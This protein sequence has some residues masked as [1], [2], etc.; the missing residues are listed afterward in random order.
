LAHLLRSSSFALVLAL[1]PLT[2]ACSVA[3]DDTLADNPPGGAVGGASGNAGTG[4]A[5]GSAAVGG[6]AG[7]GAGKAGQ[8][9]QAG[10]AEQGG[11]GGIGE[12]GGTGTIGGFGGT[13]E[14]G[15]GQAGAA[16]DSAG[17]AG[18]AGS[19]G[20]A[21]ES[22]AAGAPDVPC[23]ETIEGLQHC[24]NDTI[25]TCTDGAWVPSAAACDLG[26]ATKGVIA[27]CLS[28]SP[29]EASCLDGNVQICRA[30]GRGFD[31]DKT[32][33]CVGSSERPVCD[34]TKA[35]CVQCAAGDKLC[36]NGFS[37]TCSESGV[38]PLTGGTDC[39]G[40][41]LCVDG[42]CV[43]PAC[44]AGEIACST[45]PG[46]GAASAA[47]N[48]K[49]D[50]SGFQT[51]V[52]CGAGTSCVANL[53]CVECDE[54]T[55]RAMCVGDKVV[56]CI[57]HKRVEQAQCAAGA[58]VD[59]GSGSDTDATCSTCE[60]GSF[61]CTGTKLETCA[62]GN[63]VLNKDCG[64]SQVCRADIGTCSACLPNTASCSGNTLTKCNATGSAKTTT[65]CGA[66]LCDATEGVCDECTGSTRRCSSSALQL[67]NAQGKFE[68]ISQCATAA[69]CNTNGCVAPAC[70]AGERRC[71]PGRQPQVCPADRTGFVNDGGACGFACLDEEGCVDPTAL[72]AGV[73]QTCAIVGK[74]GV[75]VCWG[76]S[77]LADGRTVP[78]RIDELGSDLTKVALGGDF[79]CSLDRK[80]VVRCLGNNQYGQLGDG[81]LKARTKG[82]TVKL[83]GSA[84][85]LA[86]SRDNACAAL[87][88]G[89]VFCWGRRPLSEPA[90]GD[91][92]PVD[93]KSPVK[94]TNVGVSQR[95]RCTDFPD[96][97]GIICS[98]MNDF[99]QLGDGS[100][101]AQTFP[102]K[103]VT[104]E[105]TAILSG[106]KAAAIGGVG[107]FGF[108]CALT[109]GAPVC[110]GSNK[111]GQL[112]LKPDSDKHV[113]A[114]SVKSSLIKT[115]VEIVAGDAH[116]CVLRGDKQDVFCWGEE[117]DGQLGRPPS[118][119]TG[120]APETPAIVEGLGPVV[121]LAAGS[122]HTCALTK[123]GIF[124]W[125]NND[126]G[127]LGSPDF[128]SGYQANHVELP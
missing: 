46:M 11:S 70:A 63:F 1:V 19:A 54:P 95:F 62:M 92:N 17:A 5:G 74:S 98:G 18:D 73:G 49:A 47:A 2:T 44:E 64:A 115:G 57:N 3:F 21:G 75:A 61:R 31:N 94:A 103:P 77:L 123:D 33:I 9:G 28:C 8:A 126:F 50:L 85:D 86:A 72:F 10:Q 20:A 36:V 52:A 83:A 102:G 122:S 76:R 7:A 4:G 45:L 109:D 55:E 84:V 6:T 15:A 69:L 41:A 117:A 71:A 81:T 56:R 121:D 65:V 67:C 51:P 35:S 99:G 110:W 80:G 93:T 39:G 34:A 96:T 53:G 68:T 87:S 32:E 104:L 125:G 119:S 88:D 120:I 42:S 105:S 60:S 14:A 97:G 106:V 118:S 12:S 113:R 111:S 24:A 100:A 23:T 90:Q 43:Q 78:T 124:C 48:C 22:G 89:R 26:C 30:D 107:V 128:A 37:V 40:F 116:T 127:Q 58:C 101:V 112:G 59:P 108:G 29:S 91:T 25:E 13:G 66:G 38:F 79:A 27:F 114:A 16:G 82:A